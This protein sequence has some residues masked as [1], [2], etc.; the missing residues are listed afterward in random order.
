MHG[1]RWGW[2]LDDTVPYMMVVAET[3]LCA[4]ATIGAI[5]GLENGA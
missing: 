1:E 2:E 4:G 3:V 5:A